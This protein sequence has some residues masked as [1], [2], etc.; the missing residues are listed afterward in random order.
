MSDRVQRLGDLSRAEIGGRLALGALRMRIG[1]FAYALG[2]EWP[3]LADWLAPLYA[4]YP[5]FADDDC[6]DFRVRLRWRG[7]RGRLRR[8]LAVEFEGEQLAYRPFGPDYAPPHL[9]WGLN[10]GVTFH[11][12]KLLMLHA[13][14]A[15]RDGRALLLPAQPGSGKSTLAAALGFRGWRF[16]SD[17]FCLIDLQR[18]VLL[19]FPRLVALK[20]ASVPAMRAHAPTARIGRDF[21]ETAK[22]CLAHLQPP[23]GSIEAMDE[24]AVPG[25][26]VFPQ[27]RAGAGAR[28][29]AVAPDRT[30]ARLCTNAF[31][32]EHTGLPGF[33]TVARL[34]RDC[35]AHALMFGTLDD[36]IAVL[37]EL[38]DGA[39]FSAAGAR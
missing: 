2:S 20:N 6:A 1:P 19:P 5:L 9:E 27:F 3:G 12:G 16:L 36:A 10:W 39:S 11:A 32:Y 29:E 17:E 26:I 25:W 7:L 4:R 23:P 14:A 37:D 18:G 21:P 35:P 22:G 31:N 34:V 33:E 15:E 38:A 30:M 8:E 24:P 13:A 28:L